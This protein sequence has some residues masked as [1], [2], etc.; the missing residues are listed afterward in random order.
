MQ[1]ENSE[2]ETFIDIIN[3]YF[4]DG[5]LAASALD[6]YFNLQTA[7]IEYQNYDFVNAGIYFGKGSANA[8]FLLDYVDFD[9]L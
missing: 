5:A 2:P 6:T 4:G 1:E 9:S 3:Q 7:Y 8:Y